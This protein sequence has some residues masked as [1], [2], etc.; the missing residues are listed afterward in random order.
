M[1][2]VPRRPEAAA[3][4]RRHGGGPAGSDPEC[5]PAPGGRLARGGRTIASGTPTPA[6]KPASTTLGTRSRR[7]RRESG[8]T[9][10]CRTQCPLPRAGSARPTTRFPD[11]RGSRFCGYS[12]QPPAPI[13]LRQRTHLAYDLEL[14]LGDR[15]PLPRPV[16]GLRPLPRVEGVL[17]PAAHARCRP[18]CP[19]TS[20]PAS[21]RGSRS[22]RPRG[23]SWTDGMA[24]IAPC[25]RG[26]ADLSGCGRGEVSDRSRRRVHGACHADRRRL[27]AGQR[28][29][30]RPGPGGA[31]GCPTTSQGWP[32]TSPAY[33]TPRTSP[34]MARS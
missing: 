18:A 27:P 7:L 32:T 6:S 10:V 33:T 28:G 12:G 5:Q 31:G 13:S 14:G 17:L 21:R 9:S 20:R 2:P 3:S 25:P 4:P 34:S 22:T 8:P 24:C 15:R 26:W 1:G 16:P 11:R 29:A 23:Q 19:R 30:Q